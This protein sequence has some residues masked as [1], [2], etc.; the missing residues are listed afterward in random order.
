MTFPA[1]LAIASGLLALFASSVAL[2][3]YP[4]RTVK[5]VVPYAAGGPTD[6]FARVLTEVWGKN[7]GATMIVENKSGA[8][9]MLGTEFVAK[10]APDGYTIL[11]STVA[12]SVNPSLHES[13]SY[14]PIKDFS[15]VGL[16]AR[17]PLV[18]VVNNDLPA[19]T[20]TE[21]FEYLKSN[22]GKVNYASAGIGS[23]PHLGGAL[24]N[25]IGKFE[26]IHVPYRGSAPAMADVIGGHAEFMIDSA[27]TGL[28]Q[29]KAGTVRL[30][31][32][33][34]KDRLPLTPDT[35]AIAEYLPGYEAYTWNA[36]L[37][38]AGTPAE[39]IEQIRSALQK[40]LQDPAL[41]EKAN[42]MGLLLESEPNP[43]DLDVFIS[44][45]IDKWRDVVKTSDMSKN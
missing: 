16:A 13:L 15:S 35:P 34:M 23:A 19:H 28:A 4:E 44:A 41:K 26:T 20:V 43:A 5:L 8:G 30:L 36:V 21:F 24:L 45:E 3:A 9:T 37:V 6:T 14:D 12:H 22:P 39:V 1:R 18:L 7:L 17:A 31:A 38:P 27:P 32:T 11:L 29:V 33:S 10:S 2:A 40:S 42:M 25:H